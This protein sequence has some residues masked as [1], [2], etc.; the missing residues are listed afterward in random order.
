VSLSIS[1]LSIIV[2][3]VNKAMTDCQLFP[4]RNGIIFLEGK[5]RL[6]R[7]DASFQVLL[8]QSVLIIQNEKL[9]DSYVKIITIN[10]G[11]RHATAWTY[12]MYWPQSNSSVKNAQ[13]KKAE[14]TEHGLKRATDV[15]M[16]LHT[17]WHRPT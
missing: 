17:S 5:F 14:P 3:T 9:T 11:E 15:D 2:F 13:Q 8:L 7:S 1:Q 4:N 6:S 12:D 16:L 10:N